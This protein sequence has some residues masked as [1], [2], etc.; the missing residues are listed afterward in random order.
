MREAYEGHSIRI[1]RILPHA[2]S[3][4]VQVH[5]ALGEL[6]AEE[7]QDQSQGNTAIHRSGEDVVES[8]PPPKV[9]SAHDELEDE[10]DEEPGGV[11]DSRCRW[12]GVRAVEEDGEVDVA[13]EGTWVASRGVV[14]GEGEDEPDEE[15]PQKRGVDLSNR[16]ETL[17][18]DGSPKE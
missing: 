9:P 5:T 3:P 15:E 4:P 8:Q 12:E 14:E 17:R 10:T 16:E 18:A 13:E 1:R 6:K 7:D 2:I 11:V